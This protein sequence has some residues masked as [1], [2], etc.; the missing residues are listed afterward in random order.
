MK[1]NPES[2]EAQ[3]LQLP[4]SDRARLA[5]LLLGS[6]DADDDDVDAVWADEA[7]RRYGELA[8]GRV[9]GIPAEQVFAEVEA[10]L[11]RHEP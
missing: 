5:E 3:L 7:E 4:A 9:A 1:L 8:A 10:E 2:L 6:L 11:R